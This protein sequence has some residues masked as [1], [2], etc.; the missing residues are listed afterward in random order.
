MKPSEAKQILEE[1]SNPQ[2]ERILA[3]AR[4]LAF[5]FMN[6]VPYNN[7]IQEI[8]RAVVAE[9]HWLAGKQY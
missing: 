6:G 3:L 8:T 2:S 4:Q 9:Q 5:D 1:K 7:C